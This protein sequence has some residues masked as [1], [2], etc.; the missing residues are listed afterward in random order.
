MA[1]TITLSE[2]AYESLRAL[3]REGES[4]SDVVQRL[5]SAEG[6]EM[7]GFGSWEDTDL[8]GAIEEYRAEYDRDRSDRVDELPR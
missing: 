4:V 6:D 1:P 3:K 7:K 5:A 8:R 2:E